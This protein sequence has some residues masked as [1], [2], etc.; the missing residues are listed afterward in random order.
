[1]TYNQDRLRWF[2]QVFIALAD[3]MLRNTTI[4]KR[5]LSTYIGAA[6]NAAKQTR[7]L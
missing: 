4:L 7:I 2:I 6:N 5:Y 1:M 3:L